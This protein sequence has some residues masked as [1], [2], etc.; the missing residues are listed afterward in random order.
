MKHYVLD[1]D[2]NKKYKIDNEFI[3]ILNN[4]K[5]VDKNKNHKLTYEDKIKFIDDLLELMSSDEG[6]YFICNNVEY[7]IIKKF[8]LKKID[9]EDGISSLSNVPSYIIIKYYFP[10]LDEFIHKIGKQLDNKYKKV[11]CGI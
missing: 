2:T 8:N 9:N 3:F 7:L 6:D 10:E 11:I 5:Y 1:L 4:I